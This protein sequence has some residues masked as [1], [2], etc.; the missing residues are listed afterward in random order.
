[1]KYRHTD[2]QS[3]RIDGN[4]NTYGIMF[5]E[6]EPSFPFRDVRVKKNVDVK[7]YYDLQKEIGRY[8]L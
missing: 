7:Q 4:K 5:T 3:N 2:T 1:M 6:V 8:V